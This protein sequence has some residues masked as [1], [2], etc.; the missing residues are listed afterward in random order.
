MLL[1]LYRRHIANQ[2]AEKM[3]YLMTCPNERDI[4][5]RV[6]DPKW[7]RDS[8]LRHCDTDCG[9]TSCISNKHYKKE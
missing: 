6:I 9:I 4:I 1:K 8:G 7:H 3:G 5:L 2:V